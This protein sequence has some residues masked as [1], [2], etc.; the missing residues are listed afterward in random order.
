MAVVGTRQHEP[1]DEGSA[2][3]DHGGNGARNGPSIELATAQPFAKEPRF[4]K[5][6]GERKVASDGGY[7]WQ[8]PNGPAGPPQRK[9]GDGRDERAVNDGR[10]VPPTPHDGHHAEERGQREKARRGQQGH[11]AEGNDH[12][13][14]ETR[15]E[16]DISVCRF[17]GLIALQ[18]SLEMPTWKVTYEHSLV[19]SP[20]EIDRLI[21]VNR[22]E[23]ERED[24]PILR[25]C[26]SEWGE[27]GDR[28]IGRI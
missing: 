23:D 16:H 15:G 9:A 13:R 1:S 28:E 12:E 8:R 4:A 22:S 11:N 19:P 27:Q 2:R 26:P 24:E 14:D 18:D 5:P 7:E 25:S 6:R 10:R 20:R 3:K 17:A 21:A